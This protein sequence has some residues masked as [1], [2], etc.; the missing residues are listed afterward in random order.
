VAVTVELKEGLV[1]NLSG[2]P[3]LKPHIDLL[4][5]GFKF[6]ALPW[7][8]PPAVSTS[9]I[10]DFMRLLELR[11]FFNSSTEA[12]AFDLQ[13]RSSNKDWLPSYIKKPP[14]IERTRDALHAEFRGRVPLVAASSYCRSTRRKFANLS[15]SDQAV[16]SDLSRHEQLRVV[17]CDKNLG[18]AIVSAKFLQ[19]EADLH[20]L[21][22]TTYLR[23]E[24][25][26]F[27][28]AIRR[29]LLTLITMCTDFAS[30]NRFVRSDLRHV[31]EVF[32]KFLGAHLDCAIV[33]RARFLVKIH[34]PTG[35][36]LHPF[37][38]RLLCCSVQ[39]YTTN[40]AKAIH[41][42][43]WPL[44]IK[45]PSFLCNSLELIRTISTQKLPAQ[46]L[47]VTLDV[48]ALYPSIDLNLALPLIE[49]YLR[50]IKFP[51]VAF[52]MAG[53]LFI[54]NYTFMEWAGIVY[55][56]ICGTSM[57]SSA[58]PA[59]A[60]LYLSLLELALF[61]PQGVFLSAEL[62]D[63]YSPLL[64]KRYID[65][66][67]AFWP[68]DRSS[69]MKFISLL[70]GLANPSIAWT[71]V[72]SD[73][74]IN[75]LDITFFKGLD[76]ATS[77]MLSVSLY[78][79]PGNLY[80]YIPPSSA[81]LPQ[82][83]KNLVHGE[84]TRLLRA[85]S[86]AEDYDSGLSAFRSRLIVRG[87]AGA[88]VDNIFRHYPHSRRHASLFEASPATQSPA[89]LS[90]NPIVRLILPLT[91]QSRSISSLHPP[92]FSQCWPPPDLAPLANGHVTIKMGF[93]LPMPL[94][95]LLHHRPVL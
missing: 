79:K 80:Q 34:K 38:C 23:V 92:L 7:V 58:A 35:N 74:S 17:A 71:F 20:F 77:G 55:K 81:H 37:R 72:I 83:F 11:Y 43:V 26:A 28:L 88:S 61:S 66:A 6:R 46:V 52:V 54:H 56:Q 31:Y 40:I 78:Q 25:N 94:S 51:H 86:H 3:L 42:L 73:T 91:A 14:W 57:G 64:Y 93:K 22:A 75:F 19:S 59:L 16:I 12:S 68:G 41:Y 50:N 27:T 85:S 63:G 84:V 8:I 45:Q 53:L 82:V 95:S 70:Q 2:L 89:E 87:Y 5:K 18:I 9:C 13:F 36:V 39:W 30:G 76:F 49:T 24:L 65:D 29:D 1:H 21:D 62:C 33:P 10:N 47:F 48:T 60:C 69:L 32:A 4:T 44:V 90:A 67:I 15:H